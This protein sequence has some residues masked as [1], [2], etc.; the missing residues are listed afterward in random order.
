VLHFAPTDRPL[1]P[2]ELVLVDAGG[3]YRGYAS[4]IT[5]T[6]PVSGAFSA[7]QEAL[8]G[9]VRRALEAGIQ[10]CKPGAEWRDVHREAALA[11]GA[12]LV[13]LGLLRGDVEALFERGAITLFFP[14]GVGHMV[15]LGVRDAG[16]VERGRESPGPGYPSLRVDLPLQAGYTMTVEPGVYFVPPLLGDQEKRAQLRDAVDWDR[17]DR[18]LDFGGIRLEEN[19]LVTQDGCEVLTGQVPL[20]G[21]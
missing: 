4:D 14:H 10:G 21:D 7:E 16:G 20:A 17:V 5:R 18:M 19:V 3:E 9:A 1:E 12:G 15:G 11:I 8:Y 13:E 2:G 6:H